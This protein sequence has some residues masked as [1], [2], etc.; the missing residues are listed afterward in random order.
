ME[1]LTSKK[2]KERAERQGEHQIPE[3]FLANDER[4][5]SFERMPSLEQPSL[6]A[7]TCFKIETTY[8]CCNII[9]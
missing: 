6:I 9:V 3:P 1:V 5:R 8:T 7:I 4:G 2:T